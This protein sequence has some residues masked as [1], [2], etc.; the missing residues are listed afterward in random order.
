MDATFVITVPSQTLEFSESYIG[1][2]V[3]TLYSVEIT[4]TTL[5]VNGNEASNFAYD[6]ENSIYT[7]D[8]VDSSS[9]TVSYELFFETSTSTNLTIRIQNDYRSSTDLTKDDGTTIVCLIGTFTYF[10]DDAAEE[11]TVT[12]T[13]S[14]ITTSGDNDTQEYTISS[15]SDTEIIASVTDFMGTYYVKIYKDNGK[16]YFTTSTDGTTWEEEEECSKYTPSTPSTTTFT[17]AYIGTWTETAE[18]GAVTT[19]VITA[20]SISVNNEIK[21]FLY[22]DNY[23]CYTIVLKDSANNDVTCYVELDGD[24]LEIYSSGYGVHY[25]L[26]KSTSNVD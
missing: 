5:S 11:Y 19:V 20:D 15:T 24:N 6:A 3:S 2:W 25:T 18:D 26:T 21:N 4:S 16:V 22:V 9:T 13:D 10:N 12:V 7:F 14:T 17:D 8:V 23:G 1:T